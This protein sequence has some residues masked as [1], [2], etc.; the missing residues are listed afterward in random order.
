MRTIDRAVQAMALARGLAPQFRIS[1]LLVLLAIAE[2]QGQTFGELAAET[3]MTVSGIS[4]IF[5]T[6]GKSGRKDTMQEGIALL[7]VEFDP[8][9]ERKKLIFLTQKGTEF[10]D[11]FLQIL[12]G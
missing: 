6:L 5:D 7:R 10:V 8:Q 9:D 2:K 11:A 4:R 1:Q 12:E 3:D